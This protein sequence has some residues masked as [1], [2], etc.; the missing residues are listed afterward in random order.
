MLTMVSFSPWGAHQARLSPTTGT[1]KPWRIIRTVWLTTDDIDYG[2]TFS[3]FVGMCLN[4]V[5]IMIFYNIINKDGYGWGAMMRMLVKKK[6]NDDAS[7]GG[8]GVDLKCN[9]VV[10][11]TAVERYGRF[12]DVGDD[13]N[14]GDHYD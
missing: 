4:R 11:V 1:L 13:D 6:K 3:L 10:I 7:D 9:F 12:N 2:G 5:L 8:R 14:L